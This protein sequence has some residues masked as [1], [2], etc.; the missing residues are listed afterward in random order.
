[1]LTPEQSNKLSGQRR[2]TATSRE[3]APGDEFALQY[4]QLSLPFCAEYAVYL[5]VHLK[6]PDSLSLPRLRELAS[7]LQARAKQDDYDWLVVIGVGCELWKH[8]CEQN[9]QPLDETLFAGAAKLNK[10][11]KNNSPPYA[12]DGGDLF[13][14]IKSTSLKDSEAVVCWILT[15]IDGSFQLAGDSRDEATWCTVGD[16]LHAGRIY[17]GRMLHGLISSVEPVGFSARAVI[18]DEQPHHKGGCYLLTQKFI[19]DWQQ[20]SGMADSELENL[21]GRDHVG[22][23]IVNDDERAHVKMV[24][25]ND[26]D[27]IN[28]RHVAQSQPFRQHYRIVPGGNGSGSKYHLQ[29]QPRRE[30]IGRGKEEGVYQISYTKTI[31]ALT[32]TLENMIGDDE[33]YIKCRHLNYSHADQGSFFYIPSADEL[34]LQKCQKTLTVPM[35]AFF[36]VRSDN[37]YMFYNT[38]DY[39]Y[40]LGNR[41]DKVHTMDPWTPTDRVVELL[42]Y[43]F[44]RWHDTWYKRRPAP[45]LGHLS[46]YLADSDKHVLNAS[47]AE[48]KGFAVRTTLELLSSYDCVAIH[49][50]EDEPCRADPKLCDTD[51][52]RYGKAGRLFDTF[53]LHPRE[54]LVGVVPDY[55]L[56]SGYEVVPYLNEDE[57]REAFVLKLNEAGAAGHNVPNYQ[58]ILSMGVGGLLDDLKQRL[59]DATDKEARE[60]Y[61]SA[62]YAFEGVQAYLRNYAELARHILSSQRL[63][64]TDRENLE[65]IAKR[66]KRLAKKRP[67]T[68]IEAAQLVF[69]MHCCMHIAGESV[70]IGRLDQLLGPYFEKDGISEKDA[71]EIID[72]FWIKMDEKV[73]LNHRHFNDRLSRGGGAIT[74]QGGDF[75]QGAALN[76]WVQQVTVG[77]YRAKKGKPKDACNAVTRMCLRSARRLPMNAPCLSLRVHKA[78]PPD[79]IEEAAKVA[80]SGGGH[81]FLIN[82]DKIVPALIRSGEGVS[83]SGSIVDVADARDMVCDGCFEALLAGKNEFAFS[84]VP[85]PAAIEMT[86]NRGRTYAL[87]GPVH[88]MGLKESF[89]SPPPEEIRDWDQFYEIVLEHY[90][91]KLIDFYDGMLSCYGNLSRVC[92]SPLLSPL[93]DGCTESGRDMTAGGARYKLLA[94]LMNGISCAIDSL[95]AIKHMVYSDEAVF[96]LKELQTCLL[97]DWGHDMK[98][99]FFSAAI[100]EDRIAVHAERYKH[101]RKYAL[102]SLPKFGQGNE[103]VDRFARKLVRDLVD[104]AYTVIREP[105]KLIADKMKNLRKKYGTK[106]KPFEFVIT[107]GIATFEDY[108]G[109]GAFLGASADGRRCFQT[110]ASDCSAAPYP[111]DLPVPERGRA[112]IASLTSWAPGPADDESPIDPMGLGLSNGAPTDINIREDFPL[113]QLKKIIEGFALGELGPNMMSISCADAGTMLEAQTKPERYDLV[114][115]RMGGWSEF[116]VAMFPHHQE[117]HKRRPVLEAAQNIDLDYYMFDWDDN[118]VFMPTMIHM[119][120]DGAPKDVTTKDFAH[121]RNDDRYQPR[122]GDWDTAFAEFRDPPNGSGDFVADVRKALANGDYAPSFLAFKTALTQAA[123]FAVVTARGHSAETIRRGVEV[124][125]QEALSED[126]R[127]EMIANIQNFNR[128]AGT[129]IPDEQCLDEYLDL[130]AYVGVSSPGFLRAFHSGASAGVGASPEE[131][132]TFAVEQF[133]NNALRLKENIKHANVRGI[134]FG[135]SD[136]DQGNYAEMRDFLKKELSVKLPH[137]SF[138]VY[139]TSGN[140]IRVEE[141]THEARDA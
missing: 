22:N 69:S 112:A 5:T 90:R 102:N 129:E 107:P 103:D 35:N 29:A 82:D 133:V 4:S 39:L 6:S 78:T 54:K 40:Q 25:V 80:L 70:S 34:R 63:G 57:K 126:E 24:R 127:Q 17:G 37:G 60:F 105:T 94:P 128:W 47:V 99:P 59:E 104:M 74:Y 36:D 135:F 136:D 55:T 108:A 18:G 134:S 71:Q 10:V 113:D 14:H 51:P 111:S 67:T 52:S 38:K 77:G 73:L 95:Y 9:N 98:E 81:P 96:T 20:L 75:P 92:P 137:V 53:R 62:V 141:L 46:Q 66:M 85:V 21:I 68:F 27:G 93:I 2:T 8:W 76:Q 121:I 44:S 139:D 56:G 48:R 91:F 118:I 58:R 13:F 31:E 86:M 12:M 89:R 124:F 1:M 114:R 42:G 28:Y 33:G 122:D 110:V 7:E 138:F 100:G 115:M 3:F 130:N 23:I 72:C 49:P 123:L 43:S 30:E 79:I 83:N 120:L 11:L 97:C 131:A 109:V 140:K 132:K 87:A 41:T 50:R 64:D 116:F 125:I 106:T 15:Q 19:H 88:I 26:P 101:L 61:Q 84:Y 117:Q 119:Q 16:S 45:E 32:S 65:E